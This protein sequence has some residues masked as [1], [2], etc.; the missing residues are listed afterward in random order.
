MTDPTASHD[1]I[2]VLPGGAATV[3]LQA[4]PERYLLHDEIAMLGQFKYRPSMKE[5]M[6][7]VAIDTNPITE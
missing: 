3:P 7:I 6:S 1:P 4:S 2:G 5:K